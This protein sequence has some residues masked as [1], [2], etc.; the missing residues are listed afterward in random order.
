MDLPTKRTIAVRMELIRIGVP[1]E[2]I[3]LPMGEENPNKGAQTDVN[4]SDRRV[5]I[6][7]GEKKKIGKL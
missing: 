4:E 1:N 7:L 2:V 6:I 3:V 5:D